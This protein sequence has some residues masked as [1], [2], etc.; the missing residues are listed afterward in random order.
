MTGCKNNKEKKKNEIHK[1]ERKEVQKQ[2]KE[3]GN[4]GAANEEKY[5]INGEKRKRRPVKCGG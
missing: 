2:G 1:E 5:T 3:E 4:E